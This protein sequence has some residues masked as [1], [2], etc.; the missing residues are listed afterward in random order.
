MQIF[1]TNHPRIPFLWDEK[2]EILANNFS[3]STP[4]H[5]KLASWQNKIDDGRTSDGVWLDASLLEC[6]DKIEF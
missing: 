2:E 5:E 1:V 6:S 4:K 3:F